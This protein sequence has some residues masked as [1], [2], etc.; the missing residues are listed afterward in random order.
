M[1]DYGS[2][3][4]TLVMT[5]EPT[6]ANKVVRLREDFT[7]KIAEPQQITDDQLRSAI[8]VA[9][10]FKPPYRLPIAANLIVLLPY[11]REE[12]AI[13]QAFGASSFTDSLLL[14]A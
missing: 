6:W 13:L 14:V 4:A 1:I 5:E 2:Q 3:L 9:Q 11:Q 8:N 12:G 10:L 7:Q